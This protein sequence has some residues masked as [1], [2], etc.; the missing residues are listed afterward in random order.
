[1]ARA[2]LQRALADTAILGATTNLA[3]L[4]RVIAAADFAA[5]DVDTGFIER[6]HDA[7]LPSPRAVPDI[8]LAAAALW[9][10]TE[11]SPP[12]GAD[13]FSPWARRDGWRLNLMPAPLSLHFRHSTEDMAID[14]IAEH[15]AWHLRLGDR[16]CRATAE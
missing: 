4:H 8:A 9:Q 2:R 5:G 1:A 11:P 14:A 6:H 15:G 12:S 3:F 16:D 10:L 7:L 13:R